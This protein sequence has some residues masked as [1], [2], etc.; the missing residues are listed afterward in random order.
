MI[1]PG[2]SIHEP[3]TVLD[4]SEEPGTPTLCADKGLCAAQM[5]L[6]FLEQAT[7]PS[8]MAP[9]REDYLLQDFVP[10]AG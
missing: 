4:A 2:T 7:A 1:A 6:R 3:H 10:I 9:I 8:R 5:N